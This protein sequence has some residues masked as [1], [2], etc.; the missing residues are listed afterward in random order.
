VARAIRGARLLGIVVA[1]AALVTSLAV[2]P[3]SAAS[4]RPSV[5]LVSSRPEVTIRRRR[6]YPVTLD[7]GVFV[8]SVGGPLELRAARPGYDSPIRV[9]Q[10]LDHGR[11]IVDLPSDVADGW[12][13]LASFL[14][15]HVADDNGAPISN[16]A[17]TF[18]PSGSDRQRV[19]DTGPDVP[20]YP[21]YG[22][23]VNPFTLGSVWGIDKGWAVNIVDP[24]AYYYGSPGAAAPP[25]LDAPD[26]HYVVRVSI[27]KR[28][29]DLFDISK[30]DSSVTVGVALETTRRCGDSCQRPTPR[31]PS[32]APSGSTT[33]QMQAAADTQVPTIR[34]P[35]PSTLPDLIPL[36]AWQMSA[37]HD[38]RSD[39]DFLEFGATVW[40]AGPS[41][42]V[43]E[44]FR[45]TG[46]DLMDAYQYFYS[47]GSPVGR[48]PV[49]TL[50]YDSHRGHQH[51]HF[52]QFA[53]YSLLDSS[54]QQVVVSRKVAFCLGPTDPI[55]LT[56]PGANWSPDTVGL[57]TVCGTENA[58]WVREA[59]DAGWGDTYYQY[60]HG[61]SFDISSLPNGT[62]FVKVQANP[63]GSLY[64]SRSSNDSTL[65]KI[66]LKGVPGHRRVVVPPWHGI[67]SEG[68]GF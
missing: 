5:R 48:A 33:S 29:R 47:D 65:R 41:P 43:V 22:C 16:N 34:H 50:E 24:Y 19:D 39:R 38:R 40:D 28:Y 36:P 49:G 15:V 60:L 6:H 53:R 46:S 20:V 26:G 66:V 27:A 68:A 3:A 18:C 64:E 59:L 7:V 58:I 35:D 51:W 13:G 21:A 52:E 45:R 62:Y 12:N 57:D 31:P 14:Q 10:W 2:V 55:D 42:L 1:S 32:S 61:Q 9:T 30:V 11:T 63:L 44:G 23:G 4:S 67:D 25:M 8:A 56:R 17:S 37:N 54:K